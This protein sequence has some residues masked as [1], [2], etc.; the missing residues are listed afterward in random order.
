MSLIIREKHKLWKEDFI[1]VKLDGQKALAAGRDEPA[2]Y[3]EVISIGQRGFAADRSNHRDD[4]LR[5]EGTSEVDTRSRR[6][7]RGTPW[8]LLSSRESANAH[9]PL[10]IAR[11]E[12]NSN[13]FREGRRGSIRLSG[14]HAE[15]G[16]GPRCYPTLPYSRRRTGPSA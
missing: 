2:S 3:G 8:S 6:E 9:R 11:S 7:E 1:N 12:D 5:P 13:Y 15:N 14:R 10:S 4:T 16:Q